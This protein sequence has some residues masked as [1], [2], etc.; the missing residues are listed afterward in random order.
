MNNAQCSAP[1]AQIVWADQSAFPLD[2][3]GPVGRPFEAFPDAFKWRPIIELL[4]AVVLRR[5]Q[6]IALADAAVSI[7]YAEAWHAAAAWAECIA[8][9]TEPGD[10]VAILAPAS[11]SFPIAM[12]ACLA[13][14]RVFVALDPGYPPEWINLA[15]E[16]CRPALLLVSNASQGAA[17]S[18]SCLLVSASI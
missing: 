10:L 9:A 13:A 1:A 6:R 8:A 5:P 11:T 17:R 15:L 3:N 2:W 7:T 16:D 4:E 18:L 14:G 12:L